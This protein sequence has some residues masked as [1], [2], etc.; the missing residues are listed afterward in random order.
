MLRLFFLALPLGASAKAIFAFARASSAPE[1]GLTSN[2]QDEL[3]LVPRQWDSVPTEPYTL[4]MVPALTTTPPQAWT[5]LPNATLT[6]NP[7]PPPTPTYTYAETHNDDKNTH[8]HEYIAGIIGAI[9]I[10]VPVLGTI[11]VCLCRKCRGPGKDEEMETKEEDESEGR[12]S[13]MSSRYSMERG[14]C[15]KMAGRYPEVKYWV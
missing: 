8:T 4:P 14:E 15:T 6:L 3:P 2:I 5:P 7:S 1:I 10:G 11:I 12:Q 13:L 9:F